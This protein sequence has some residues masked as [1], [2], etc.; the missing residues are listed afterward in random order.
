ILAWS[1][2][3]VLPLPLVMSLT[4]TVPFVV[5]SLFHSSCPCWGSVAAKNSVLLTLV[6][7]SGLDRSPLTVLT[8]TVPA[9]V[10]LLF[11]SC[12]P[13]IPSLAVKKSVPFTL[14][15]SVGEELPLPGA[16]SAPRVADRPEAGRQRASRCSRNRRVLAGRTGRA[17]CRAPKKRGK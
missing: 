14:V 15:S 2:K 1:S 16:M 17:R 8:E 4:R 10:P 12:T 5:P 11:H 3:A 7:R 13:L 9:A 6:S